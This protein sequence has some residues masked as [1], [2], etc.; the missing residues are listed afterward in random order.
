MFEIPPSILQR[1]PKSLLA[2]LCSDDPPVLADP[3]GFFYFDRDWWL[4][5]YILIF[6][7]DGTLPTDRNLL[8]QIYREAGMIIIIIIIIF[9]K[10]IIMTITIIKVFG[11]L[12]NYIKQS[13]K[14]NF[15]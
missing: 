8:T 6:L 7:R 12:M 9:T 4:F 5:R 1:D 13:R 15:T 14:K 11:I 10:T 2:Q 3:E